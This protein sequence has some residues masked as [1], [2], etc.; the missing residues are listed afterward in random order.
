MVREDGQW[1]IVSFEIPASS[2][3]KGYTI[4]KPPDEKR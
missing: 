1:K 4:R 2:I 3:P